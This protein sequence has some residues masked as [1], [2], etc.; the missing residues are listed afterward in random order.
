MDVS[1]V[2]ETVVHVVNLCSQFLKEF[3]ILL[4]CRDGFYRG[5]DKDPA[6]NKNSY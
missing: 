1:R 5:L 4:E 2:D 3:I 6:E